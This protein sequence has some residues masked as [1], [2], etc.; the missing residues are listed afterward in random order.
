MT[1]GDDSEGEGISHQA[2]EPEFNARTHMV[3]KNWQSQAVFPL[4]HTHTQ[5]NVKFKLNSKKRNVIQDQ[6]LSP[7]SS[8][9]GNLDPYWYHSI[10]KPG[11][12]VPHWQSLKE[13]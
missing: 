1:Q 4:F 2:W 12:L 3:K 13:E 10:I 7:K 11:S 6:N 5:I 8:N 9:L